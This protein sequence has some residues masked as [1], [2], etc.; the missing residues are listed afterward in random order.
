HTRLQAL[1]PGGQHL[2]AMRFQATGFGEAQQYSL[3]K[4][5]RVQIAGLLG[6]GQTRDEVP[7]PDS[8]TDAQSRKRD[9]RKASQQDRV[10]GSVQAFHW[11]DF[12]AVVAQLAV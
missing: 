10:A 2:L 3:R 12:G 8:P 4:L 5:V 1:G 6:L 9:L 7:R 11:R